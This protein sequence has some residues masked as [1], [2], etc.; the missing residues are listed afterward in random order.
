MDRT[1]FPKILGASLISLGRTLPVC[2]FGASFR[3]LARNWT[4]AQALTFK[5]SGPQIFQQTLRDISREIWEIKISIFCLEKRNG[6]VHQAEVLSE[7]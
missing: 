5:W 6:N 2:E 1:G 4:V 7:W 3:P